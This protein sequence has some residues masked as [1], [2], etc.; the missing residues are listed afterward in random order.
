MCIRAYYSCQ[1]ER[2]RS[3]NTPEN[4]CNCRRI[5]P[6]SSSEQCTLCSDDGSAS[7]AFPSSHQLSP[8]PLEKPITRSSTCRANSSKTV[9]SVASSPFSPHLITLNPWQ[10]THHNRRP[11]SSRHA[12]SRYPHYHDTFPQWRRGIPATQALYA[13]A[14]LNR[15]A[16]L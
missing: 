1:S 12:I 11:S 9:E 8:G 16:D 14:R 6:S 7:Q 3:P 4:T 2:F 15:K 5:R 13:A 10:A